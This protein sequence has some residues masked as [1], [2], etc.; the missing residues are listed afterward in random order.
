MKN[1]KELTEYIRTYA[2]SIGFDACGFAKAGFMEHEAR[3]LEEWLVQNRQASMQW[4]SNNFDK[5]VDPTVLVPDS[6][7]VISVLASYYHPSQ[8]QLIGSTDQ[9]QIAKYAL[10]RDYHKVIK[11][12][13]KILFDFIRT[14]IGDVQGRIFVD[15]APV[16]DK[17]WAQRAGLGWIGK[18]SNLLNKKIGSYFLIGE[19]IIDLDL[20]PDAP[21]TDHCGTCTRCLDACPTNAIYEPYRVDANKCISYWTIEHRGDIEASYHSGIQNWVFGCDICQDVCPWNSHVRIAKFADLHPRERILDKSINEWQ[22]I[23]EEDFNS[24]FEGSPVKRTKYEG[25]RR[26]LSIVAENLIT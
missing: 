26:N 11:Q 5:R 20:S 18:N 15:S 6:K 23:S 21:Q 1:R 19:L 10:G 24:L 3:R 22:S 9:P 12:K 13:L 2:L 8:Q 7:T 16:L 17:A 14:E 4:M 25:F